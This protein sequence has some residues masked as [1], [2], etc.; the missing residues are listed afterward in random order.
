M[1]TR[2]VFLISLILTST[3][4]LTGAWPGPFAESNPEPETAFVAQPLELDADLVGAG[5]DAKTLLQKALDAIAPERTPWLKTRILQTVSDAPSHFVAE[6]FLQR[7][8]NRCAR[9]EMTIATGDR[10]SRLIV[11]SDG[12]VIAQERRILYQEPAVTVERF[13]DDNDAAKDEL[14]VRKGCG[15]PSAI[16]E[17]MCEHLT[18]ATL[19]TGMLGD[20]PVIRIQGEIES[21]VSRASVYL[22]A[23]T[24]WLQRVEWFTRDDNGGSRMSLRIEFLEPELRRE[25]RVEEC[26]RV[27][28]YP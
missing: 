13:P 12:E 2:L 26:I 25:M 5:V 21:D 1:L 17:Q 8:P 19:Q 11:V 4:F 3:I 9:L 28:S 27:F 7:G 14:L 23:K 18:N 20:V 22:H 16:L 10:P 24:L 15:G 6:G